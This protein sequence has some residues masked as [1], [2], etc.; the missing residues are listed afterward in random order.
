[1]FK[2]VRKLI[3][4]DD[5]NNLVCC[6]VHTLQCTMFHTLENMDIEE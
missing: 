3:K 1:M 4:Y 2:H 6:I 5:L